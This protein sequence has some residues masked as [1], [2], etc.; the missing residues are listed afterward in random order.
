MLRIL[1]KKFCEY[2]PRGSKKRHKWLTRLRKNKLLRCRNHLRQEGIEVGDGEGLGVVVVVA[3][4]KCNKLTKK[5]TNYYSFL[6]TLVFLNFFFY[7]F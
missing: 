4:L 3:L 2:G 6:F 5:L 1:R 7:L